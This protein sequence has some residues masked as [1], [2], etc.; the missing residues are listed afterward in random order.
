ME[1]N[2][3]RFT[4]ESWAA[5]R[6]T[7]LR[8]LA[9]TYAAAGD[10][11][12]LRIAFSDNTDLLLP[13][14]FHLLSLIPPATRPERY[15]FLLPLLELNEEAARKGK[16]AREPDWVESEELLGRLG[17]P[18]RVARFDLPAILRAWRRLDLPTSPTRHKFLFQDPRMEGT[19]PSLI[20][21][22]AVDFPAKTQVL[23][24]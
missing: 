9:S 19:S 14:R 13:F 1:I 7:D 17:L 22:K 12:S 3:Q 11:T 16:T 10:I 23:P 4:A 18:W 2:R 24:P 15:K 21:G 8:E 20:E 5:F 6:T